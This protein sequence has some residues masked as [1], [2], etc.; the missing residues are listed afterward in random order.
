MQHPQTPPSSPLPPPTLPNPNRPQPHHP[1]RR[2]LR[3]CTLSSPT[4]SYSQAR[5]PSVT[6]ATTSDVNPLDG[7]LAR[8]AAS[9]A[10]ERAEEERQGHIRWLRPEFQCRDAQPTQTTALPGTEEDEPEDTTTATKR[11]PAAS[12]EKRPWP[13]TLPAQAQALRERLATTNKP[14]TPEQLAKTFQRANKT[15]VAEILETLASLGQCQ[16][17]GQHTY[18]GWVPI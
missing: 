15:R 3:Y 18:M 9:G 2:N 10:S 13:N 16:Q 17:V 7:F 5:G 1:P 12:T 14:A 6:T 8:W 4:L 11:R